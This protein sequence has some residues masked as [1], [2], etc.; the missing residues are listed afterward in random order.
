ML[1]RSLK[2][3]ALC[4]LVVAL[5][6]SWLCLAASFS[7]RAQDL[8]VTVTAP[9]NATAGDSIA[10]SLSVQ[11]IGNASASGVT[12]ADALPVGTTFQSLA[13]TGG[14]SFA[15]SSP[16]V[17]QRGTISLSRSSLPGG[18][19]NSFGSRNVSSFTQ[20]G[21]NLFFVVGDGSIGKEL[22]K[23]DGTAT[24][25]TLVKTFGNIPPSLKYPPF[26]PSMIAVNNTLFFAASDGNTGLELWKSDGTAAGTVLV[27]DV[28]SGAADSKP[29]FFF[30]VNGTLFFFADN[31]YTGTELWKSN[32]TASGTVL[33][34]DI[35]AGGHGCNASSPALMDGVLYFSAVDG[36]SLDD[37]HGYQLWRSD[38]TER[39][40]YLLKNI[41]P[42]TIGSSPPRWLTVVGSTLYF[43]AYK[44]GSGTRLWK[45]NGTEA[46]TV[47]VSPTQ[48]GTSGS[49]PNFLSNV[50]GTL[51]YF[52]DAS[53]SAQKEL[54][55]SDGT[56]S[57]TVQVKGFNSLQEGGLP[58]FPVALGNKLLFAVPDSTSGQELW[59]S[60]GTGA[61][62]KLLKDIYQGAKSSSSTLPVV[63]SGAAFFT[64]NDGATGQ[65]LW[66]TD[67]TAAGTV[68]VKDIN[69][70]AGN[71][72]GTVNALNGKV[73]LTGDDG[74]GIELWQSNGTSAG[75][76]PLRGPGDVAAFNVTVKI[77][78]SFVGSLFN[79][80]S[81]AATGGD[82]NPNNNAATAVTQVKALPQPNRAPV[83]NDASFDATAGK[84][85]AGQLAATDADGDSLTY[86]RVTTP[87]SGTL[88]FNA[89]GSFS[90]VSASGFAGVD[91]FKAS[92][93][94]GKATSAVATITFRVT[95]ENRA[96]VLNDVSF[97]AHP[98]ENLSKAIF[99]TDADGDALTYARVTNPTHGTLTFYNWGVFVYTPE[100][101]FEG[102]DSFTATASD[103]KSTS[104]VATI[105]INV[106]LVNRAPTL[107]ED[108]FNTVVDRPF[109]RQLRAYDADGDALTFRIVGGALAPGLTLSPTGL[110][111]GTPTALSARFVTVEVAD[112][113][114]GTGSA[115]IG[116]NVR[117]SVAPPTLAPTMAP[118]SPTTNQTITVDAN[119]SQNQSNGPFLVFYDFRV[120]GSSVQ[121]GS[122]NALDLSKPGQGNKNDVVSCTVTV[123]DTNGNAPFATIQTTVG[124]S[125]PTAIAATFAT[126]QGR[127]V[128]GTLAGSDPDSDALTFA[129]VT[130]PAWGQIVLNANGSFSYDS[131]NAPVG[132]V[133]LTFTARDGAAS[134]APAT[135]TI[136]VGPLNHEPVLSAATYNA[137]RNRA[138][139]QQL[140]GHRCRWRCP[141]LLC[142]FRERRKNAV[143][144][145]AFGA[146]P[147]RRDSHGGGHFGR[148]RRCPRRKRRFHHFRNHDR[149]GIR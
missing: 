6:L 20:V 16:A 25:T 19:R 45:S 53:N 136:N 8:A 116:I 33:V 89:N 137:T 74:S 144:P 44:D 5:L 52:A 105:T 138:F 43:S 106:K 80:A 75:T 86:A 129:L 4:R 96:P 18:A 12:L 7:A 71:G 46:G 128:T 130:A 101:T 113:N 145:N 13:Q 87:T 143:G 111:S 65:E 15:V 51:Y 32:G 68:H 9:A 27:K 103:G 117:S 110:I 69:P 95:P 42:V 123:T 126:S 57:G 115:Q 37:E 112:G 54:W 79:T 78:E 132:A 10:Y 127:G 121:S 134:S 114:G 30:N 93:S 97:A 94:D 81:V 73:I 61:G 119:V 91:S 67:G 84:A 98:H 149:R 49:N 131:Q 99:A 77:D 11:N 26:F 21:S 147:D 22:W 107:S 82:A 139:S 76:F 55:K 85:F 2:R 63:A 64:A 58:G 142:R 17:G 122:S 90:Y 83:L 140:I 23:T 120:N 72:A 118:A 70:G 50:N 133:T 109:S 24:G 62:T 59:I 38:G 39:G 40:T 14:P 41:N 1:L 92:A 34:K 31:G 146:G 47:R 60:D 104:A 124:N 141:I 100:R 102:T 48:T 108:V 29:S 56:A 125:A 28:N 36:F 135:A 88:N 35:Y 66:K 3:P 148:H